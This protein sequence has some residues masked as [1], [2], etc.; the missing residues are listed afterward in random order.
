[1]ATNNSKY[2]PTKYVDRLLNISD[3]NKIAPIRTTSQR[4][5]RAASQ[6]SARAA[7]QRSARKA[8]SA[9]ARAAMIA[10]ARTAMSAPARKAMI[11][12]ARTAS[13]RSARAAR[14]AMIAQAK[15]SF[16]LNDLSEDLRFYISNEY[17][18]LVNKAKNIAEK[19]IGIMKSD[20]ENPTQREE[21]L[22]ERVQAKDILKTITD[23]D[24]INEIRHIIN[25]QSKKLGNNYFPIFFLIQERFIELVV[26]KNQQKKLE[27]LN[28]EKK[29]LKLKL[30]EIEN[31]LKNITDV[32]YKDILQYEEAI[33]ICHTINN[34]FINIQILQDDAKNLLTQNFRNTLPDELGK[35]QSIIEDTILQIEYSI[36]F[37]F[38]EIDSLLNI[39]NTIYYSILNQK[40]REKGKK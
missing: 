10:P 11:A 9:P 8:M 24:T 33:E 16:G 28:N 14:T 34:Y 2:V 12:P 25:D 6:R 23:I 35:R 27:I 22:N 17:S 36:K 30:T 15:P 19:I 20:Y 7:S 3:Y 18:K 26:I 1:M 29:N 21:A 31:N 32:E 37:Y 39:A 4:S 13:Q 38:Y 40:I 5:A